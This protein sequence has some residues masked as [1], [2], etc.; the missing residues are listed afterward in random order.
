M[1]T[2]TWG[3][4]GERFYETGVSKG[5]L[6]KTNPQGVY[7]SGFA[8]NG[9]TAV[10]ESPSGAESNK[11]YADN[12]VYVNLISAEEFSATLEA[13]TYPLEFEECDGT[14]TP[15]PGISIGQQNRKSF[16]L[17][18]QTLLGNDTVGTDLGYKI[19]LVYGATAAPTEKNYS[20]VNDSPEAATF[21]WELSTTPVAVPGHKNS[22]LITITSNQVSAAKLAQLEDILYGTAGTNPRLPLPAEVL[23]IFAG[24]VIEVTAAAPTYNPTTDTITIPTVPGVEYQINGEAVSGPVIITEDTIVNARTQPGY[25][26]AAASDDDWAFDWS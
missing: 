13:F 20:T 22:A 21:S 14:A 2:L 11:Q 16:G 18:Y 8:W 15:T 19:H 10:T 7:N 23:S 3:N 26:F 5:V 4:V 25:K 9:I 6:Y 1:T 24:S 12:G 17:S